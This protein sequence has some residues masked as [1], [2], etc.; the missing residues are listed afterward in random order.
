MF[1]NDDERARADKWGV[2]DLD[3]IYRLEDLA[4]GDCIFAATGVTD[5]SLLE[6]VK[7][8]KDTITTESVVMR[9]STGTVRW[10]RGEHRHEPGPGVRRRTSDQRRLSG[11][12]C[13]RMRTGRWRRVA[14]RLHRQ[15]LVRLGA[16]RGAG[17]GRHPGQIPDRLPPPQ[18][19]A[20]SGRSRGDGRVARATTWSR[21]SATLAFGAKLHGP[22]K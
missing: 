18:R 21:G 22:A 3:R 13:R 1:R 15:R 6:G 2:T 9:A 14:I 11:V 10:V 8:R 16:E 5:G 7:R 20:R 4:K 12:S 19:E 17:E